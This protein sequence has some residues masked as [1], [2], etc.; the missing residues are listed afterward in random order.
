M[1]EKKTDRR[2]DGQSDGTSYRISDFLFFK[3]V[4]ITNTFAKG[5]IIRKYHN[6]TPQTNPW[7]CEEES[8]HLQ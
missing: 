1:S 3:N 4:D 2:V 7:H 6:H 8:Q 5:D